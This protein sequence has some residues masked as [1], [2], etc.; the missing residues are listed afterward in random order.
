MDPAGVR[1]GARRSKEQR[2]GARVGT[3]SQDEGRVVGC[4]SARGCAFKIGM[5]HD[6]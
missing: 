3:R 6:A 2:E 5:R 1:A 4:A